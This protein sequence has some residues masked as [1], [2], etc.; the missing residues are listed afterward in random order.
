MNIVDLMEIQT[1]THGMRIAYLFNRPV[2]EAEAMDCQKVFA[3]FPGTNRVELTDLLKFGIENGD[4]IALRAL[5][6]LGAGAAAKRHQKA[7]EKL[8]G[9]LDIMPTTGPRNAPGRRAKAQFPDMAAF[10]A[11]ASIWYSAAPQDYALTSIGRKAGVDKVNR[12]WCNHV[13]GPRDGTAYRDKK[14]AMQRRLG[15]EN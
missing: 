2:S 9:T 4:V 12:N 15:V 14:A 13:L 7:I 8:G 10:E 3:D 6:D 5:S 11:G 1:H